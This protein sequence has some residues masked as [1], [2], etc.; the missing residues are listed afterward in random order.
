[1]QSIKLEKLSFSFTLME[2][3][4]FLPYSYFF[5]PT[6]EFRPFSIVGSVSMLCTPYYDKTQYIRHREG[7]AL[8]EWMTNV[9]PTPY[10][11]ATLIS[12]WSR[13]EGRSG[14]GF[15]ATW[16]RYRSRVFSAVDLWTCV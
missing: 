5:Q 9:L 3:G 2:L 10:V 6:S 14:A 16:M 1:M 11:T 4:D 7:V 13:S 15:I 8:R 12:F